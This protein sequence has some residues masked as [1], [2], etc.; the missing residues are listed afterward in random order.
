MA[1]YRQRRNFFE[2]AEWEW[3]ATPG[4]LRVT[5]HHGQAFLTPWGSVAAVRVAYAPTRY[6]PWRHLLEFRLADGRKLTVDNVHFKGVADF[7]NRSDSYTP[8]VRAA[9]SELGRNSPKVR[10]RAGAAPVGYWV[11]AIFV[12]TVFAV[13]AAILLAIPIDI[14]PGIAWLKM[15]LIAVS[16]PVLA[17]W[18]VRARPRSATLDTIPESSLPRAPEPRR[19]AA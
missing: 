15:G 18:F 4:G 14:I 11:S 17:F 5:D 6:K 13:L 9:L 10:V 16:L 1:I 7:E 2:K 19:P 12:L 8:F 3:A